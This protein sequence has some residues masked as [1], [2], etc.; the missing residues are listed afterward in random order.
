MGLSRFLDEFIKA[1]FQYFDFFVDFLA[2]PTNR[3]NLN[4][5]IKGSEL[6]GCMRTDFS[7]VVFFNIKVAGLN[8]REL[9]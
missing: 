5:N 6:K 3:D 9:K 8:D 7:N 4:F 1:K 2:F